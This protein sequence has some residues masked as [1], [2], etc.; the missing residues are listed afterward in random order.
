[1]EGLGFNAHPV[2][3]ESDLPGSAAPAHSC[4]QE[5][6]LCTAPANPPDNSHRQYGSN[7]CAD[8]TLVEE[9]GGEGCGG[10]EREAVPSGGQIAHP[11]ETERRG[12]ASGVDTCGERQGFTGLCGEADLEVGLRGVGEE[13][14]EGR[15]RYCE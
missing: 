14:A 7:S 6:L 15:F 13:G 5:G 1:M 12:E 3:P 10:E 2:H 11:E 4:D 9:R 8:S